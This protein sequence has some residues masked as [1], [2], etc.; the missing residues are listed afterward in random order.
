[1]RWHDLGALPDPEQ[2]LLQAA[3]R[4]SQGAVC[5]YSGFPVGAAVRAV[6]QHGQA[7]II[8]GSNYETINYSSV[9]AEK[10]AI[11]RALSELSWRDAQGQTQRPRITDVAVYCGVAGTPQ[12]PCGNCR[13]MLHEVNPS[14]RV[15][16]WAGPGR[17]GAAHDPRVTQTT[18]QALLPH[19]FAKSGFQGEGCT[20]STVVDDKDLESYVVHFPKPGQLQQHAARREALLH[21]VEYLILVG[22][23]GR[24]RRIAQLAFED[25]GADRDADQ[26]CYCDLTQPGYDESGREY[27]VY[28]FTLP[29]GQKVAAVSHGIG[30]SGAEIVLGELPALIALYQGGRAPRIKGVLRCGT[31][32]TLARVPL[33]CVALTTQSHNDGLDALAPDAAW[34]TRLRQAAQDRQMEVIHADTLASLPESDWPALGTGYCVEGSGISTRFFWEGQGRPLYRAQAPDPQVEAADQERRAA[35]LHGWHQAGIRWVE[36]EDY[37]VL[38]VAAL[39]GYPAVTL[40]AVIANRRNAQ[41]A[42]QLDYSKE[43]L[44]ASELLPAELALAAIAL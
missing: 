44:A 7:H 8:T 2:D 38:R 31:R 35:M 3:R 5:G 32:G 14:M 20:E 1:M 22:S 9:C 18:V 6:D 29:G 23:P 33:G 16:A 19:S 42:W 12:Q 39:C 30:E 41:G 27:A 17:G 11:M 13:Q 15:L 25:Y 40:G 21:D 26:A 28:A 43:A 24:A 10:H 34:L 37:A 4:A 36:M